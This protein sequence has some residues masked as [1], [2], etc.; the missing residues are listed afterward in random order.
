M[1]YETDFFSFEFCK[2]KLNLEN[3]LADD[4]VEFGRSGKV[5]TRR[6][7]INGLSA[8]TEDKPYEI[9]NFQADMLSETVVLARYISL[10][11]ES[12]EKALRSSVW[13]KNN[14]GWKIRFHQGTAVP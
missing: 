7:V 8:I 3:R 6:D 12:G 11:K 14:G 2:N 9:S 4:F 5:W 13:V 10:N 1:R